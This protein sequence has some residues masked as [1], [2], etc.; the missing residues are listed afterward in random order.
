MICI[1]ESA[2]LTANG[3]ATYS[4]SN[5]PAMQVQVFTPTVSAL[6][7]VTGIDNNGCL[8]KA[9]VQLSVFECTGLRENK[10]AAVLSVYPNPHGGEFVIQTSVRARISITNVLGEVIREIEVGEGASVVSMT[11]EAKGV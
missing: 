6:Y 2:T 5:G 4:W 11:E 9:S 3:A 7:T 1:G 10:N 8:A